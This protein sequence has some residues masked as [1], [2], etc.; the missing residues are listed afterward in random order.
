TG[1]N[2]VW[3]TINYGWESLEFYRNW[4]SSACEPIELKGPNLDPINPQS[5]YS[6]YLLDLFRVILESPGYIERLKRHYQMFRD[7]VEKGPCG[8]ERLEANRLDN[9]RRRLRDPN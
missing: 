7:S 5:E 8:Q 2:R 6:S 1:W 3:A 4:T 9:R